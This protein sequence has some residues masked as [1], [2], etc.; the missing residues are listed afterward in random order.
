MRFNENSEGNSTL[1]GRNG[2]NRIG[3][4]GSK[5]VPHGDPTMQISPS[6]LKSVFGPNNCEEILR[7]M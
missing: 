7:E 6:S 1:A 4:H 2:S 5:I 3:L